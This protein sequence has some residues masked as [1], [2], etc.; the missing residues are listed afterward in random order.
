MTKIITMPHISDRVPKRRDARPRA[1]KIAGRVSFANLISE[2][3]NV[4]EDDTTVDA[5]DENDW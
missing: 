2:L 3:I 4:Q 1:I 5:D